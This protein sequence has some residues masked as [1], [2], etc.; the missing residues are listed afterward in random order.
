MKYFFISA[1]KCLHGLGICVWFYP[2][3]L[4]MMMMMM[5]ELETIGY[6]MVKTRNLSHLGLIRYRVVTDGQTERQHCATVANK[7]LAVPPAVA[8]KNPCVLC[9]RR[10]RCE[11]VSDDRGRGSVPPPPCQQHIRVL[12]S[13]HHQRW[14]WP[15]TAPLPALVPL[16]RA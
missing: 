3:K 2:N 13:H 14:R 5:K 9:M 4:M 1:C 6:H 11:V 12:R 16:S 7:R 15:T 10:W 8:R